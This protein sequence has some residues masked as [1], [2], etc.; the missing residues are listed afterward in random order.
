MVQ[1][2]HKKTIFENTE[3][4]N[5]DAAFRQNAYEEIGKIYKEFVAEMSSFIRE[6][7]LSGHGNLKY[8]AIKLD[9]NEYYSDYTLRNEVRP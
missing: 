1:N 3:V 4:F 8:L 7:E 6:L 5:D 2:F 9:F